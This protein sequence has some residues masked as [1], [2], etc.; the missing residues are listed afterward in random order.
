MLYL[1]CLPA[2]SLAL[3]AVIVFVQVWQVTY[4]SLCDDDDDDDDL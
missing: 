1:N 2:V 4:S 3:V